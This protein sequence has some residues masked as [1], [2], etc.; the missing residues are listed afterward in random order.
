MDA[1]PACPSHEHLDRLIADELSGPEQSAV[2][3]HVES[4]PRCQQILEHL[5]RASYAQWQLSETDEGIG[6]TPATPYLDPLRDQPPQRMRA[7]SRPFR[8]L[9][10]PET[11]PGGD[12]DGAWP[13]LPG[14]EVVDVLGRGGMG[15]VCKARQQKLNRWVALK[16][17]RGGRYAEPEQRARFQ[18]EAWAVAQLR[19][20][21]IVQIYEVGDNAGQPYLVLEL[22]EGGSLA[23]KLPGGVWPAQPAAQLVETVARAAQFAHQH[24]VIHRDLKPANILL[25]SVATTIDHGVRT[26]EYASIPKIADFGLAKKLDAD[27]GQ[28]STGILVGTPGYMAPEQAEGRSHDVGPATDVHALGV[29]LYELLTGRPPYQGASM[30]QTLEQVRCHEPVPPRRLQPRV[31]RDLETIC[32]KCLHKEPR[33]RYTSAEHLAEDLWRFRN[34]KPIQARPAGLVE[35][36]WKWARR[37]PALA[38]LLV[39][40][41]AACVALGIEDQRY[42]ARLEQ[43]LEQ[44]RNQRD[45]ADANLQFARD[46]V[47]RTVSKITEEPRL[48]E[49]DFYKLRHDLLTY[50]VPFYLEFVKQEQTDPKLAAERAQAF[51][52][53][54]SVR[55]DMGEKEKAVTEYEQARAIF[56]QLAADFPDRPEYCQG[57]VTVHDNMGTVL[58]ELGKRPE[59]EA[60]YRE[61]LK[62]AARLAANSPTV[63]DYRLALA[64]SYNNLARLLHDLGRHGQSEAAYSE[65]LKIQRQLVADFPRVPAYRLALSKTCSNLGLLAR[66]LASIST[67]PS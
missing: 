22:V 40:S 32:L 15:V 6:H 35:Q 38:A 12:P 39:V 33:H 62:I 54:G 58:R 4:C 57:L 21:N 1:R 60:A 28:T 37:R 64:N 42:K 5:T 19:H 30:L 51:S 16:M 63:V 23:Q 11:S 45:R 53:L 49:A 55:D 59:A 18:A 2:E 13:E 36:G 46:A 44:T 3:D 50:M 31:P 67:L 20:P 65:S 52:R 47:D 66:A 34:G 27:L 7:D 61:A 14:Y 8:L 29:I 25:E 26:T 9:S 24:G 17:L 56:A 41:V 10:M 43:A 48:K